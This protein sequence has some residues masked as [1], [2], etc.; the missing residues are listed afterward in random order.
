MEGSH[1]Y[2]TYQCQLVVEPISFLLCE[3][4]PK[5]FGTVLVSQGWQ[6]KTEDSQS[7]ALKRGIG[8]NL[9]DD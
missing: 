9:R 4:G 6:C 2:S 8:Q 5:K 7:H 3:L 1:Q